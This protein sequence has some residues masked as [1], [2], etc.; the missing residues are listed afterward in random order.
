MKLQ[1][2]YLIEKDDKIRKKKSLNAYFICMGV[3]IKAKICVWQNKNLITQRICSFPSGL[4]VYSIG[5][6]SVKMKAC[7]FRAERGA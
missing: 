5:A 3:K 6:K 2:E 4:H 1:N 7:P